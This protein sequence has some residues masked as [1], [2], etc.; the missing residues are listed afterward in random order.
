MGDKSPKQKN[1][2]Q[3]QKEMEKNRRIERNNKPTAPP[4]VE[5]TPIPE[6]R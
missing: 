1:K 6:K 2:R 4:P 5:P 3:Q